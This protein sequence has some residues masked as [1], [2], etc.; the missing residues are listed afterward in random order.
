MALELTQ[1]Q[2]T[3][4]FFATN[5]HYS[6]GERVIFLQNLAASIA[7]KPEY[8]EP[9][10]DSLKQTI[11]AFKTRSDCIKAAD[12]ILDLNQKLKQEIAGNPVLQVQFADALEA[13]K[14]GDYAQPYQV[15]KGHS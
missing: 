11:P 8:A 4:L 12:A 1:Q 7:Q 14:A 9:I 5:F 2:K 3:S 10:L 13:V 15:G 6:D